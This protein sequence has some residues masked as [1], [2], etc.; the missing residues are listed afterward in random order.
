[1]SFFDLLIVGAVIGIGLG[2]GNRGVVSG[3]GQHLGLY[4]GATVR[5]HVT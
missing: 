4:R 3:S 5:G 2:R 1:M